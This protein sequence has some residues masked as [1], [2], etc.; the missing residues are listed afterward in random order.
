MASELSKNI[1]GKIENKTKITK[2]QSIN[3]S[4]FNS[5]KLN[6][7]H[8]LPKFCRCLCCA[9]LT[10]RDRMFQRGLDKFYGEIKITN[11]IKTI[12][13]L[14]AHTKKDFSKIQWRIYKLQKGTRQL[15]LVSRHDKIKEETVF[16]RQPFTGNLAK[17]SDKAIHEE[18]QPENV[19]ANEVE[20]VSSPVNKIDDKQ[21]STKVKI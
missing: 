8:S 11:L 15:H 19:A 5:L 2:Y 10:T 18:E 3:W 9:K 14:K 13:I 21:K 12:R 16:K 6:I 17:D 1:S 7:K 4:F 20:K